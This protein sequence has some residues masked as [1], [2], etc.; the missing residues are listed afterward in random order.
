MAYVYILQCTDGSYYTGCTKD[1]EKRIKTHLSKSP[2][3]AKYTRA[4]TICEVSAVWEVET[5]S[6]ASKLEYYIKKNFTHAEKQSLVKKPTAMRDLS[7]S[8]F[9]FEIRT[10][11]EINGKS[12]KEMI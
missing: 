4:R 9:D 2:R 11:E 6:Q 1:V 12:I 3:A 5:Y 7:S 10:V 8:V